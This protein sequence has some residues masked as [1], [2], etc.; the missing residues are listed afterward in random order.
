MFGSFARH[1]PF[2][3]LDVAVF[4]DPEPADPLDEALHLGA[5]LERAT[6]LP[7]D[8]V[9]LNG[10]PLGIALA[11]VQG[12]LVWCRDPAA[13]RA[14]LERVSLWAMDTYDLR[15]QSLRDLLWR[16]G[17]TGADLRRPEGGSI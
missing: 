1:R 6:G 11:A 3:D 17:R 16:S 14:F 8:V 15:R 2:R 7:V 10:A 12:R 4:L 9:V 13:R 5:F